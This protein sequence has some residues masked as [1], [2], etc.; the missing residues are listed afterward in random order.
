MANDDAVTESNQ[1]TSRLWVVGTGRTAE[2]NL[3]IGMSIKS[4]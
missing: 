3:V 2:G 1:A 4:R